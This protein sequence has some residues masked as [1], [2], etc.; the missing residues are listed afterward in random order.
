M[1]K[2]KKKEKVIYYDDGSTIAD[3][4]AVN[5]KGVRQEKKAPAPKPE[6]TKFQ[7]FWRAMKMMFL[8]MC[9]VLLILS[10]LYVGLMFLSGNW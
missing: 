6:E 4:S 10:L 9:V 3:M 1:S 5:S 2:K 8:P 7:T